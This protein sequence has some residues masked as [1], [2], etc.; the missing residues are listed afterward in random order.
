MSGLPSGAD[1]F[2]RAVGVG[3]GDLMPL[4]RERGTPT[5]TDVS[6]GTTSL[7]EGSAGATA[8]RVGVPD[9][10]GSSSDLSRPDRWVFEVM[11]PGGT[12]VADPCGVGPSGY[13]SGL[14]QCREG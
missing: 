4:L 3:P 10:D 11:M 8:E 14:S 12:L 7:V 1:G 9:P 5:P 13:R 6:T 2:G